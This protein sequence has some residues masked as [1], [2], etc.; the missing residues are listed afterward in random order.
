[1]LVEGTITILNRNPFCL[2]KNK[3]VGIASDYLAGEKFA[4]TDGNEYITD[5]SVRTFGWINGN[6]DYSRDDKGYMTRPSIKQICDACITSDALSYIAIEMGLIE[7][8]EK[9]T[10][11][12][13]YK[14]DVF[15]ICLN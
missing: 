1:M 2:Y 10:P 13:N 15:E 14:R 9:P 7:K 6:G 5:L 8:V 3:E 11:I 12:T 4:E